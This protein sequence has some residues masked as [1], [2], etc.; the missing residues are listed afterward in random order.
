MLIEKFLSSE[1]DHTARLGR[2]IDSGAD[3]L[4][5][6]QYDSEVP[7]IAKQA[8]ALGWNKVI[9]GGDAWQT[10][11]LMPKCGDA[12]K[13]SYFSSHFAPIGAKGD[14]ETFVKE[15]QSKYNTLPTG[16]AA[17]GYD[18]ANLMLAA[19]GSLETVSSNIMEARA[20]VKERLAGLKGFAGVS[21]SLDMTADG[22]PVKS[23]FIIRINDQGEFES[24]ATQ[25]P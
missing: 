14:G 17:L 24:F 6:P 4:F 2:I 19:I 18:A 8:R 20:A 12:C 10:A 1:T 9:L 22:D 15:Y 13:G 3:V 23:A 21:G 7:D 25:A 5:L 11:E 16:D